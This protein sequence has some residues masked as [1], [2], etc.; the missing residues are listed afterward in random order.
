MLLALLQLSAAFTPLPALTPSANAVR[1]EPVVCSAISSR[2]AALLAGGAAVASFLPSASQA[3]QPT[4]VSGSLPTSASLALDLDD[5][6]D[7]AVLQLAIIAAI[8]LPSPFIGI[9]MV[10]AAFP[11]A[12]TPLLLVL[13]LL[14][15]VGTL[16]TRTR[17]THTPPPPCPL[18]GEKDHLGERR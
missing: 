13:Y 8:I 11:R 16:R 18:S 5:E 4:A 12:L 17:P 9:Q 7:R 2:R 15:P 3:T 10:C 1:V 6:E 14:A